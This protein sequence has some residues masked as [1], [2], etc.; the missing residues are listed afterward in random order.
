M[1]PL[2]LDQFGNYVV[3]CCLRFGS[4]GNQFIFDAMHAK[5]WEIGQGRFGARAM[6]ACLESQY[7][8]KRQQKHV[9]IAIVRNSVSL[10]TNPN[11]ALL[12]TW[13]L[14]TSTLPGRYR[15]LA[16]KLAPHVPSLC[17][18]KLA[19]A[20]I[21]KLDE[22]VFLA[23]RVRSVLPRVEFK[24][25][26]AGY[27]RLLDELSVIS[28]NVFGQYTG[29]TREARQDH[30]ASLPM[31]T[32]RP[33]QD[34]D[35]F[36]PSPHTSPQTIGV[37]PPQVQPPNQYS[38]AYLQ[39]VKSAD[40][41][42]WTP[43]QIENMARWGNNKANQV[44]E[45]QLPP[46]F[47][48]PESSMDQWIRAKYD[49]KQYARPGPLPNPD[50]LAL[51]DGV[52][53]IQVNGVGSAT[54]R[55][56]AIAAPAPAIPPGTTSASTR[57]STVS[58]SAASFPKAAAAPDT[59]PKPVT[60]SA[61]ED[62]F[63][64]FQ[65]HETSGGGSSTAAAA[66]AASPTSP[67]TVASLKANIMSLYTS[68]APVQMSA[69]N[70]AT[71]STLA[72]LNGNSF[73]S[74]MVGL[75]TTQPTQPQPQGA[76]FFSQPAFSGLAG[77][78]LAAPT[79]ASASAALASN[80]AGLS[81]FSSAPAR[82]GS[83]ASTSST[84]SAPAAFAAS[85]AFPASSSASSSPLRPTPLYPGPRQATTTDF[86]SSRFSTTAGGGAS[87]AAD[88]FAG[89]VLSAAS[90]ARPA[91]T[92]APLASTSQAASSSSSST[93]LWGDFQ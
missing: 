73:S 68:P 76:E 31:A 57:A 91:S 44:W 36:Y 88:P 54:K 71:S 20:T 55:T 46:N 86:S 7:T 2:L 10:V 53:P 43:E 24:E 3:Q 63:E 16:P 60:S 37:S 33:R 93:D 69:T 11:G 64:A 58:P 50:D 22:R 8:T 56:P 67:Q 29:A 1:E 21:L 61:S 34:K 84:A 26:Q 39:A 19:S 25:T 17:T 59:K 35:T 72:G 74:N 28:S 78:S 13:L 92:P 30:L 38:G 79:P 15:V 89:L 65:S 85:S 45:Y 52:T 40:L 66:A 18:H 5:C 23:D 87:S 75:N 42:T 12:I 41:D 83:S 80:L 32:Q 51:P 82:H 6:R 62:L 70:I 4:P 90:I 27:K 77:L 47:E 49:R 14:D 9:A 48:P 81:L